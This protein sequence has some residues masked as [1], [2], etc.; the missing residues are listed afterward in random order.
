M[1][2]HLIRIQLREG[3]K[4]REMADRLG[5]ARSTWTMVK[6]GRLALSEAVMMRAAR[7]FPEL[8]PGL[9]MSLSASDPGDPEN[10]TAVTGEKVA[11]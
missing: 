10:G 3:L 1:R 7:A 11:S 8:L 2:E 5:V 9:V 6:I 4:D